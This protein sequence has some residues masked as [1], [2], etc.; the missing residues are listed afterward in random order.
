MTKTAGFFAALFALCLFVRVI[1]AFAA[2][3]VYT[4]SGETL[5]DFLCR[6]AASQD[7]A[8]IVSPD[9]SGEIA[10]NMN[11]R[12]PDA[13]F[14]FLERSHNL[15]TYINDTGIYYYPR[16][17][18]Q[19]V[20]LP[21]NRVTADSLRA[22][23]REMGVYDPRYPLRTINNGKMARLTAPPEYITLVTSLLADLDEGLVSAKGTR[24][25]RLKHAWADDIEVTFLNRRTIIPGIASLLWR[26]TA[27]GAH[28]PGGGGES[29]STGE[30]ERLKG[31]GLASRTGT[32]ASSRLAREARQAE[33]SAR[34]AQSG[35]RI[36]A[37]PRLNAVIVWD[38]EELMPLY[39]TLIK[40][41]DRPV[42]LVEIR[43]A[44]VDVSI[45]RLQELGISWSANAN[46]S[47]SGFGVAGGAN[48]PEG[49]DFFTA[50]GSG[51]NLTTIFRSGMD[52][53]MAR[54]HALEVD[55]DAS[56]LSRPA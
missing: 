50:V 29:P 46:P 18:M 45:D 38:D 36:L 41:L 20:N 47:G 8:C 35:A 40:E 12:T 23:L 17:A 25:F 21:L 10:G 26:I 1:P 33:G 49:T 27:G 9:I 42:D 19:S 52:V 51:L 39:E 15:I 34:Q 48:T 13:F 24:V 11:F 22:A 28:A 32:Q 43:T 30:V 54:I 16:S 7:R 55:G 6:Y 5:P 3:F 14:A 37:D 31:A 4:A 2:P 44:I 56:V 53:F